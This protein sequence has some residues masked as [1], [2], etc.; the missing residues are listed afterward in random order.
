[1][2]IEIKSFE[3]QIAAAIKKTSI[4]MG[5]FPGVLDD[6]SAKLM[7]HLSDN[8]KTM[9]GAPYLAYMNMSEDYSS[10][11]IEWGF[12]VAEPI[13]ET[14]EIYMSQTFGGKAITA[15]HKGKYNEVEATYNK[16][17]EYQKENSLESTGVWY[18]YYLNDPDT[19]A[20]SELLTQVLFPI[21]E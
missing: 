20:E 8:G 14:D 7:K 10:F 15:I 2:N 12:P 9:I 16:V 13:P 1:M 11:D 4:S 18:D 17:M 3:P 6:M 21:K 19:V 5:D